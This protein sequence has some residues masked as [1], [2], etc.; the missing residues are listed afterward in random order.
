MNSGTGFR[1]VPD[2][3]SEVMLID[4]TERN[5][6]HR[7][8]ESEP[9]SGYTCRAEER[10]FWHRCEACGSFKLVRVRPACDQGPE[11]R[12]I[13]QT[14]PHKLTHICDGKKNGVG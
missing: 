5:T 1:N 4:W 12:I 7:F 6:S 9:P 13:W 8:V 2:V 10:K 14:V 11:E 3:L